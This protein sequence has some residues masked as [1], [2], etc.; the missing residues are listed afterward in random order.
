MI[1]RRRKW[2]NFKS[3]I[4]Y[5]SPYYAMKT[6]HCSKISNRSLK[7]MKVYTALKRNR[8]EELLTEWTSEK[9]Y[10]TVSYESIRPFSK[11]ESRAWRKCER[12]DT[13]LVQKWA[14]DE[15]NACESFR[16]CKNSGN[17]PA[18]SVCLRAGNCFGNFPK[19]TSSNI[20]ILKKTHLT[21]LWNYT[22][23]F[24]LFIYT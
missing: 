7:C 12:T 13:K 10:T 11:E 3:G 20:P 6:Q 14:E 15:Y 21:F 19:E 5:A 24:S 16:P 8:G 9:C 22:H 4:Y 2:N 18:Y 1:F 23:M 17:F